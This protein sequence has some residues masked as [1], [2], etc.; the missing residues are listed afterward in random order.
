MRTCSYSTDL[1]LTN[2]I[3]KTSS[4]NQE[5]EH[6]V[7]R[8]NRGLR[9]VQLQKHQSNEEPIE[10]RLYKF[11]ELPVPGVKSIAASLPLT[12]SQPTQHYPLKLNHSIVDYPRIRSPLFLP[13]LNEKAPQRK[14]QMGSSGCRNQQWRRKKCRKRALEC[15]QSDG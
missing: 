13:N 9:A 12:P 11:E 14:Y 3:D 7:A 4:N 15:T 6:P 5:Q 10:N 8:H 1:Y 2:H